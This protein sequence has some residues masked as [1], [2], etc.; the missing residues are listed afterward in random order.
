MKGRNQKNIKKTPKSP[1][2]ILKTALHLLHSNCFH[3]K[4]ISHFYIKFRFSKKATKID[5]I[6][7]AGLTLCSKRQIDGED[8]VNFCGL[9]RKYELYHPVEGTHHQNK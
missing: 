6:F 4:M 9:L 1:K 2:K 7:I 5:E 8:F 3:E